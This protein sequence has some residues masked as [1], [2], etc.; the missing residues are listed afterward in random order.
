MGY[1]RFP[2]V[3]HD[4]SFWFGFCASLGVVSVL[5]LVLGLWHI[6]QKDGT[7][8]RSITAQLSQKKLSLT[9]IA[10]SFLAICG[11]VTSF[12]LVSIN[13]SFVEQL[14]LKDR[15]VQNGL[16]QISV[17]KQ[18]K[19][20][21]LVSSL[22]SRVQREVESSYSR[23][24][25]EVTFTQITNLTQTLKPYLSPMVET[26]RKYSFE[27]GQLFYGLCN[28]DMA[29]SSFDRIISTVDF[30]NIELSSADLSGTN[31]KGI[32]LSNSK[33]VTVNLTGVS[34]EGANLFGADFSM[35]NLD[36]ADLRNCNLRETVFQRSKMNAVSMS[37]STLS[38]GDFSNA[39]LRN[40]D[41]TNC[42]VHNANLS[43]AQLNDANMKGI[44][45]NSTNLS[46][47][48][49]V[50]AKLLNIKMLHGDISEA[51]LVNAKVQGDWISLLD[52]SNT[53]GRETIK[54]KYFLLLDS[55]Q[56]DT[57]TSYSLRCN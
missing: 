42:I 20:M 8:K 28:S 25:S 13:K 52:S 3:Q 46:F 55:V 44:S 12:I 57:I 11:L 45:L 34:L 4:S 9:M 6:N 2:L 26:D 24:L 7:K 51:N 18:K 50:R 31:L 37:Q 27:K 48:T 39:E 32:N 35:S 47:A 33:I 21:P 53:I 54:E 5:V 40:A 43:G 16:L 1:I 14:E 17:L 15:E 22:L 23:E 10:L 29:P 56:K 41:L 38:G 36:S 30:S 19:L 49:M